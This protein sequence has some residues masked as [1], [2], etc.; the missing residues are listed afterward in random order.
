MFSRKFFILALLLVT[1]CLAGWAFYIAQDGSDQQIDDGGY[2][3]YEKELIPAVVV[4]ATPA[5]D[6][7]MQIQV[8]V[9]SKFFRQM[10]TI[11]LYR[12][13]SVSRKEF[14]QAGIGKGDSISCNVE[15]ITHGSC[16]PEMYH[17]QWEAYPDSSARRKKTKR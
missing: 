4:K 6:S 17:F 8:A 10:D 15:R 5:T 14:L 3:S 7:F 16:T 1:V 13:L 11:D 12:Y 2:C 9:Y